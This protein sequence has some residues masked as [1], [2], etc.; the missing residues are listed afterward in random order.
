MSEVRNLAVSAGFAHLCQGDKDA[1]DT[2]IASLTRPAA[3]PDK[4][5]G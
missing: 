3:M 5:L 2:V 4:A 1:D